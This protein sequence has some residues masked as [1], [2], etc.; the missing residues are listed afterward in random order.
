MPEEDLDEHASHAAEYCWLTARRDL[1][2]ERLFKEDFEAL[3]SDKE[4]AEFTFSL[5]DLDGDGC[6]AT[7]ACRSTST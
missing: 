2:R 7:P 4:D 5:F 3:L 1:T 6:T